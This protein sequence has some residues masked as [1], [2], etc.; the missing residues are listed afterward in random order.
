MPAV[1]NGAAPVPAPIRGIDAA[2]QFTVSP[3]QVLA[4]QQQVT[5]STLLCLNFSP[6]FSSIPPSHRACGVLYVVPMLLGC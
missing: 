6:F 3:H 4:M 5:T 2:M 1:A